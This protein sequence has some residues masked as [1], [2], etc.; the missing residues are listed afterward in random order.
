MVGGWHV[1]FAL[2]WDKLYENLIMDVE[3]LYDAMSAQREK[4]EYGSLCESRL[5]C[6]TIESIL[7]VMEQMEKEE[8]KDGLQN[9]CME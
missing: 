7:S 3:E 5:I 6:D 9:K 1:N 2:L 4:N 8:G